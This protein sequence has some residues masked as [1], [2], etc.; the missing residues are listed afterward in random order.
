MHPIPSHLH[1]PLALIAAIALGA[2]GEKQER[3]EEISAV[4]VVK[5][6]TSGDDRG[7]RYTGDVR[8]RYETALGFRV[9]GKIVARD[10]EIGSQV[11]RGQTLARLD[12]SDF[13]LNIEAARS[14]LAAAEVGPPPGQG[15]SGAL[16]QSVRAEVRQRRRIRS[17]PER[18]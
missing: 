6:A 15:R 16:P 3:A 2:C 10:V 7:V 14:Q 17:A 13:R 1:L 4:T 12:P 9:P 8:A 5:V 11:E 18:L